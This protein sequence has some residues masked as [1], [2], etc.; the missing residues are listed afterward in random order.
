MTKLKFSSQQDQMGSTFE[1]AASVAQM[2]L[3]LVGK[4][5]L[6]RLVKDQSVQSLARYSVLSVVIVQ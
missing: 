4:L 1:S 6:H 3:R 5:E 2:V